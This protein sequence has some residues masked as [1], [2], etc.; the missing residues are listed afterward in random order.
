MVCLLMVCLTY[1]SK[2]WCVLDCVLDVFN[3]KI[4]AY[5]GYRNTGTV[6]FG[7]TDRS[8]NRSHFLMFFATRVLRNLP[9]QVA[10]SASTAV[11]IVAR[12]GELL[13]KILAHGVLCAS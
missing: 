9:A 4:Y 12:F 8:A 2:F 6:T 1:S 11:G 10:A 13:K 3:R 7:V 5:T